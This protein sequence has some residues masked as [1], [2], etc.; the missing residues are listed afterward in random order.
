MACLAESKLNFV[1]GCWVCVKMAARPV[2]SEY[3]CLRPVGS[4]RT[5]NAMCVCVWGGGGGG[6]VKYL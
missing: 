4:I 3:L 6:A 2:K 1:V 5:P